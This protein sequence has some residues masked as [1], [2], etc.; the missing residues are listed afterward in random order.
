MLADVL[1]KEKD[2]GS[3]LSALGVLLEKQPCNY[4]VMHKMAL[5]LKRE[6]RLAAE[7]PRLLKNALRADSGASGAAGY[8]YLQ[9]LG[10]VAANEVR[11]V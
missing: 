1:F 3:A 5:L 10:H 2:S 8:R 4:G 7:L 6:R 9:A 11:G